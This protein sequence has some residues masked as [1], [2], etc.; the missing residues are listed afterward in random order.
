VWLRRKLEDTGLHRQHHNAAPAHVCPPRFRTPR[1]WKKV[2]ALTIANQP[3]LAGGTSD[4][5]GSASLQQFG[6][7]VRFEECHGLRGRRVFAPIFVQSTES[8]AS[9]TVT[10]QEITAP[11]G[12]FVSNGLQASTQLNP[13]PPRQ[14][15]SILI[16]RRLPIRP[17]AN[18]EVYK[19]SHANPA[20]AK[21]CHRKSGHCEPANRHLPIANPAI[22]NPAIVAALNHGSHNCMPIAYLAL[23]QTVTLRGTQSCKAMAMT[24]EDDAVFAQGSMLQTMAGFAIAGLADCGWR[25]QGSQ[26]PI[27]DGRVGN[28]RVSRWLGYKTSALAMAGFG[29]RRDYQDR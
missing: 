1:P 8:T 18:A 13:D 21:P 12:T 16:I 6:P 26:W 24:D 3:L 17:I 5:S 25:W 22:A 23:Q 29:N 28:R 27:C 7:V 4:P 20:I 15:S 11:G 9:V 14:R 2:F 19:P 10:V